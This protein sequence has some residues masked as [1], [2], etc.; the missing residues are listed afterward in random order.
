MFSL[1]EAVLL[2]RDEVCP[3]ENPQPDEIEVQ[4]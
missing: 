3:S 4:K 2:R 1:T